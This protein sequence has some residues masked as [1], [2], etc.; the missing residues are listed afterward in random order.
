MKNLQSISLGGKDSSWLLS[1]VQEERREEE[2]GEER[3]QNKQNKK[4][5]RKKKKGND[6]SETWKD[7]ERILLSLPFL[8]ELKFSKNLREKISSQMKKH[9]QANRKYYGFLYGIYLLF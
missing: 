5:K 6:L 9:L 1:L 4:K 7:G 2:R 8:H 3:R